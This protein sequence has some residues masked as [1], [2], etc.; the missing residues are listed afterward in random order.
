MGRRYFNRACPKLHIHHG[1]L[2]YF[3]LSFYQRQYKS[4][5]NEFFVSFILRVNR[6]GSIAEH[7]LGPRCC[8]NNKFIRV[9]LKRIF[10][11][12]KI[13]LQ[14]MAR[15]LFIREGCLAPGAPVYDFAI[16]VNQL[17]VPEGN[18]NSFHRL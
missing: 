5:S 9:F 1:V 4:F 8:N 11:M 16:L 18:K 7:C 3:Y 2:N 10:K 13:P 17:F 6:H 12:V 15:G 14:L